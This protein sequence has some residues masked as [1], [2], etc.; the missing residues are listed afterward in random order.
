MH[1]EWHLHFLLSYLLSNN[2][3]PS[4]P[5]I[6]TH[7]GDWKIYMRVT[8]LAKANHRGSIW[9]PMLSWGYNIRGF[10]WL[11]ELLLQPIS[12]AR[13]LFIPV[14]LVQKT[15]KTRMCNRKITAAGFNNL[16]MLTLWVLIVI[17]A[18]L[19]MMPERVQSFFFRGAFHV[20]SFCCI[21]NRVSWKQNSD[22]DEPRTVVGNSF[23]Y[24]FFFFFPI[25]HF[26]IIT[27]ATAVY[28]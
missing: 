26:W 28:L 3:F 9:S 14:T 25:F 7:D 23:R 19:Q 18:A 27:I 13:I 24:C 12:R 17:T 4:L 16:T 8:W 10:F 11:R 5:H 21:Q 15:I 1:C 20:V 22:T 6:S 2:Q